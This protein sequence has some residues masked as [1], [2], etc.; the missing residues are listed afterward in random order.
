MSNDLTTRIYTRWGPQQQ[1][2]IDLCSAAGVRI[3]STASAIVCTITLLPTSAGA[4]IIGAAARVRPQDWNVRKIRWNPVVAKHRCP[5]WVGYFLAS[6][7]RKLLQSPSKILAPHVRSGMT[8][9]DLGCAMG[10]FSLPMAAMV[11]PK[12]KVV[13][14]DVEPKMLEV[15][16]NRAA[17]AGLAEFIETHRSG[18]DALGLDGRPESFD[19]ALAFAVLHELPDQGRC[20]HEVHQLLAPGASLLV[21]EPSSH[22]DAA[23]FER[24]IATATEN[25]FVVIARPRIRCAH[26]VLLAKQSKETSTDTDLDHTDL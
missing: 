12:G 25:N 18:E 15:L 1:E 19:F 13:C 5:V 17:R 26:A 21:A 4:C 8:V 16:Q 24:T 23:E 10:F 11:K 20:F 9:L 6:G 7:L 2:C 14:V 3:P 22:V